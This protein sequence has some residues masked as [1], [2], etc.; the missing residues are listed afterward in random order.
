MSACTFSHFPVG[1]SAIREGGD[2]SGRFPEKV[3]S[4]KKLLYVHD[5]FCFDLTALALPNLPISPFT[6]LYL[7]GKK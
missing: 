4:F 6:S 2:F 7:E 1:L 5:I 3:N